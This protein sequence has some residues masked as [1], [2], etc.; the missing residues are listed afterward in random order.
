MLFLNASERHIVIQ[1]LASDPFLQIN[2]NKVLLF[3]EVTHHTPVRFRYREPFTVAWS[4]VDVD[5]AEVVV[6]LVA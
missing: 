6:F 2:P 5:S 3:T 1:R 4:D